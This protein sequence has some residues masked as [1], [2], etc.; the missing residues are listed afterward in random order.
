[1]STRNQP[2]TPSALAH[3]QCATRPSVGNVNLSLYSG[4]ALLLLSPT[5][6][7]APLSR[8][9]REL[10][11]S[12]NRR[13]HRPLHSTRQ[14]P[15]VSARRGTGERRLSRHGAQRG[16]ARACSASGSTPPR[17]CQTEMNRPIRKDAEGDEDTCVA[18][19]RQ[20]PGPAYDYRSCFPVA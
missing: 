4:P 8:G 10:D 1:M 2:K 13:C 17:I 11:V 16:G 18:T 9:M 12:S 14:G 19:S 7:Q 20:A 6:L 15:P 3:H 5:C